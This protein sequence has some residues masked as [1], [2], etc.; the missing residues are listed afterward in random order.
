MELQVFRHLWGVTEPLSTFVP[1]VA[2]KG[3]DGIEC[4]HRGEEEMP[5]LH[6]MLATHSLAYI[7]Q[8]KTSGDSVSEHLASFRAGIEELQPYDPVLINC[9][10]GRDAFSAEETRTF[11]SEAVKIEADLGATVAHETHRGRVMYNPWITR[12]VLERFT[13]VKLC[14][15]FSHWVCVCERVPEEPAI[16]ELCAQRAI[17]VHARVGYAEG[18]QVPDPRAPEYAAVVEAHERWWEQ[19]WAAQTQRG[20]AVSRLTPEF[21]PPA[22]LHTLPHT[23]VPVADLDAVCDWQAE[24]QRDRF[25]RRGA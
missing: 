12:D 14:C 20:E 24:R 23:N 6:A 11:F 16:F 1:K 10:S 2:A 18:P 8:M 25:Q 22:Y 5:E 17:H 21:G 7:A 3:Y 15:D 19:I 4:G 9:H 13:E